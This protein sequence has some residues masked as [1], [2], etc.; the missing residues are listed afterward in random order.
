MA[1]AAQ[2]ADAAWHRADEEQA[3]WDEK[4]SEFQL[5]YLDQFVAVYNR[6]VVAT[7]SDLVGLSP[8][9]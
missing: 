1:I 7:A 9:R 3:F 2:T 8:M 5:H 6:E 4:A